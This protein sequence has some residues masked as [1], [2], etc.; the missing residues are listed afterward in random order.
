M[1]IALA[2]YLVENP[3]HK[4]LNFLK[5]LGFLSVP[6]GLVFLQ[7]DLGT[8]LVFGALFVVMTYI[9]GA[10]VWQIGVLGLAGAAVFALAVKFGVL[11][12]Y[13]V[14]RLTAFLNP[15]GRLGPRL[16]GGAVKDGYRFRQP[17]RQGIG[18]NGYAG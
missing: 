9:G 3:I 11:A 16:P 4:N 13:Q 7:P 2:G 8:A 1:V 6:A 17:H 15:A 14:A 12:D 5:A 18:R 10:R